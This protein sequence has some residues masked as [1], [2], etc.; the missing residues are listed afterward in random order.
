MRPF[1]LLDQA[2]VTE[3]AEHH[4]AG[5]NGAPAIEAEGMRPHV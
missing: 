1:T 2:K 4:V 5:Q 3:P